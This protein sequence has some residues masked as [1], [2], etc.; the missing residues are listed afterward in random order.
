[1][2]GT[3]IDFEETS[4]KSGQNS[5]KT[6]KNGQKWTQFAYVLS[7]VHACFLIYFNLLLLFPIYFRCLL[8]AVYCF[9]MRSWGIR[10]QKWQKSR[11]LTKRAIFGQKRVIL[12]ALLVAETGTPYVCPL[13]LHCFMNTPDYFDYSEHPWHRCR[14]GVVNGSQG[15]RLR[16]GPHAMTCRPK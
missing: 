2:K 7:C 3:Y 5:S 13:F 16:H 14:V 8:T 10:G 11:K 6:A 9:G 1:M 4:T 12:K 15:V